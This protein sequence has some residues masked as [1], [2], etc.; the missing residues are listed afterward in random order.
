MRPALLVVLIGALCGPAIRAQ[1]VPPLATRGLDLLVAGHPDSAVRA[2]TQGW[3]T[4]A[5]TMK[6]ATLIDAFQQLA[7]YAGPVLGYDLIRVVEITPHLQRF[8]FLL[9]CERQP[10]YLMVVLYQPKSDWILSTLN[11]NTTADKVMPPTMFGAE[12]P[13]P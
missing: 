7:M 2:W 4:P 3:V 8:Y 11:F 10:A 6:R 12:H 13:G 1:S 9:R 5:D